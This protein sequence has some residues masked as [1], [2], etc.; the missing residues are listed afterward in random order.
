MTE[1]KWKT[2][3]SC[4]GIY[5]LDY[6]GHHYECSMNESDDLYVVVKDKTIRE[7][8]K[9][10][11]LTEMIHGSF[12]VGHFEDLEEAALYIQDKDLWRSER[13]KE[14]FMFFE[15]PEPDYGY[16]ELPL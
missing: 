4:I 2:Q 16:R 15:I 3:E 6:E 1:L 9:I 11:P 13:E 7:L 5:E 10:F 8:W 14:L 12:V